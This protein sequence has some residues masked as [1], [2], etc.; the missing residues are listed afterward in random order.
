MTTEDQDTHDM[1]TTQ[2]ARA[3]QTRTDSTTRTAAGTGDTTRRHK[4]TG[5]LR[6][7]ARAL[8]ATG[9]ARGGP[10]SRSDPARR[11]GSDMTG[12]ERLHTE[13]M[14]HSAK[15]SRGGG[16]LAHDRAVHPHL[17][18]PGPFA[19][20]RARMEH[21]PGRRR[22]SHRAGAGAGVTSGL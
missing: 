18:H 9:Q 17:R 3:P 12:D 15:T 16:P 21:R 14:L 22:R 19:Y 6:R 5:A 11:T 1:L 10:P 13:N 4:D 8:A 2:T 7:H 20:R